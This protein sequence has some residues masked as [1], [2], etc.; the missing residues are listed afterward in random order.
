MNNFLVKTA[1]SIVQEKTAPNTWTRPADNV[2]VLDCG[3]KFILP[4]VGANGIDLSAQED[5][6]LRALSSSWGNA[7]F[8]LGVDATG[9]DFHGDASVKGMTV[10]F[11][12]RKY[13]PTIPQSLDNAFAWVAPSNYD[14]QGNI[15]KLE[16]VFNMMYYEN[17]SLTDENGKAPGAQYADRVLGHEELHALMFANIKWAG[18]L[19]PFVREGMPDIVVGIKDNHLEL[20]ELVSTNLDTLAKNLREELKSGDAGY[21]PYSAGYLFLDFLLTRVPTLTSRFSTEPT[22]PN[23]SA[24]TKTT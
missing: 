19:S 23:I 21:N 4:N 24:P 2:V 22:T 13:D 6:I 12:S 11:Q 15:Q 9:L 7:A 3:L 14:S 20:P 8:N 5:F 17:I 1:E 16:L 10:R 18:Y